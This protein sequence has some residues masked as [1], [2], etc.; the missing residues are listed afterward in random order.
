[1]EQVNDSR[2]KQALV[3]SGFLLAIGAIMSGIIYGWRYIPGI[4]GET[5]G[6]LIGILTTPFLMEATLA[7][8][9]LMI[10]IC[11]NIRRREKEGNDF[12]YLEQV[13]EKSS[14][15]NLPDQAKWAVYREKPL[16][17]KTLSLH[18]QAEGALSID[19]FATASECIGEMD[20]DE[21][22][23]PEIL[24]LRLALAKATG[25]DV[26]ARELE[27]EIQDASSGNH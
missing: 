16:D 14:P 17:G 12:V 1:M 19:D 23:Q 15:R 5:A 21:L 3:G 11:I 20:H 8:I 25:K 27:Q 18:E 2:L 13:D 4:L 26:M 10:V 7:L 24:E 6:T 9:G 22:K